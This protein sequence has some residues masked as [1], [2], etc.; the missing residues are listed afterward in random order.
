MALGS[1]TSLDDPP[2]GHI[3][4]NGPADPANFSQARPHRSRAR[5]D[6]LADCYR[7][8]HSRSDIGFAQLKLFG[9]RQRRRPLRRRQSRAQ[10]LHQVWT[11]GE[12]TDAARA[13]HPFARRRVDRVGANGT[14][15]LTERLGGVDDERKPQVAAQ[16]CHL[17]QRL[18]HSAVTG[19]RRQMHQV[20]RFGG[21]ADRRVV[22]SR[23]GRRRR[24]AASGGRT[25]APP[26][27][28]DWARI[29]RGGRPATGRRAASWTTA[30]PA[31]AA[32]R[33]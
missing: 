30:G 29:R 31:R 23:P 15:H 10:L 2:P 14:I 7:K 32:I 27:G 5:R 33:W 20:R 12:H 16:L 17:L 11:H 19:H 21:Q 13:G 26:S 3:G 4:E 8:A 25:R 9:V 22:A 1:S 28:P 24:S 18:H 6:V